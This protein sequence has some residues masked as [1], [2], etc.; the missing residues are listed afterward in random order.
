MSA[1]DK[2]A[3]FQEKF[4]L[5]YD[6]PPRDLPTPLYSLRVKLMREELEE[7]E[8]AMQRGE[9]VEQLDA[10]VDL[11]YVIYGTAV[12]CG[13]RHVLKEAFN[14]V[15][16]ANMKKVRAERRQDS[17]RDSSFDII[18]PEGWSPP[19]LEDLIDDAG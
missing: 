14:R 7:L 10:F 3:A 13:Y 16:E 6:G 11:L 2:V 17:K 4:G 5:G 1:V 8:L 9:K 18:K 15:H 19:N 12:L